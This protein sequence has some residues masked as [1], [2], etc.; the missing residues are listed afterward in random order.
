MCIRDRYYIRYGYGN[1]QTEGNSY[2]PFFDGIVTGTNKAD[3]Y[4]TLPAAMRALPTMNTYKE[5][6]LQT[7]VGSSIG[8]YAMSSRSVQ[9]MTQNQVVLGVKSTS[10]GFEAG[11]SMKLYSYNE[12]C[13]LEFDAEIY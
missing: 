8:D 11:K 10:S 1:P 6:I 13:Y 2:L 9:F 12:Q 4:V 7:A 3:I 5:F